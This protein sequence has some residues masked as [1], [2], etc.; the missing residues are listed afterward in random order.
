MKN[1]VAI[2]IGSANRNAA[3][4]FFAALGLSKS[5]VE[6]VDLHVCSYKESEFK[7][8]Y[9]QWSPVKLKL[10]SYL[11]PVGYAFS[12]E[13]YKA[14]KSI[15]PNLVHL[16]GLWMHQSLTALRF[17]KQGRP[18]LITPH[19]MLDEWAVSRGSLKKNIVKYLYERELLEKCQAFHALNES[20]ARSIKKLYPR[21]DVFIVPNGVDIPSSVEFISP[22]D[23][24][25]L[26]LGRIDDKKSVKELLQ[27]WKKAKR[28]GLLHGVNLKIAGWGRSDYL[29]ETIALI[30]SMK[31]VGCEYL[32]SVYGLQKDDLFR[33]AGSFILPSKSEGLPMSILEAWSYKKLVLMTPECNLSHSF[34]LKSSLKINS[35]SEQDI[36][37]ALE[38]LNDLSVEESIAITDRA[39]EDVCQNYSWDNAGKMM[40]DIYQY[41]LNDA[42]LP[43]TIYE[44]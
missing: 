20:E 16:H 27:A 9:E 26:Y 30:N 21:S 19:G 8:D 42:I 25:M 29:D 7:K 44:A 15:R 36:Y 22:K 23:A 34:D 32:G 39:F 33:G 37:S 14:V 13:H 40:T 6:K 1:R 28:C 12:M 31:D 43:A 3:G 5:M 18:V 41:L 2:L 11:G 17:L 24:Y 38:S 4:V 10:C 35:S